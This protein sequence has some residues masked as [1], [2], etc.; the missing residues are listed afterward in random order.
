MD[1]SPWTGELWITVNERDMLGSDLVPDYLTN[2]P[3]GAQYGWPWIYYNDMVDDR[4]EA[5]MPQFLMEYIRNPEYAL[6]PHVAALGFVF[7]K[8]AVMGE[9]FARA[10]SWRGMDRGTAS[11]LRATTWSTWNSTRAAIRWASRAGADRSSP[12]RAR[13]RPADLGRVGQDRRAAGVRRYRRDH[14]ARQRAG[15]RRY[16]SDRAGAERT[17]AGAPSPCRRSFP[18][19][20]G[21]RPWPRRYHVIGWGNA[22]R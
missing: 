22:V 11:R 18:R 17:S 7:T 3:I 1:F 19:I 6:G 15:G 8:R 21:R 16:R 13:P 4:V 14:L 5:P 9:E 12:A 10:H 20:R 2:V